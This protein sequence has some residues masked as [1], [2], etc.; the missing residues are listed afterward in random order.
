MN[1]LAEPAIPAAF[2]VQGAIAYTGCTRTFLYENRYRLDWIK[3]GRRSLITRVSLDRLLSELP[4]VI[5]VLSV[6][7]GERS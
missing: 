4:R 6:P 1:Q 5:G 7:A 3:A 2:T